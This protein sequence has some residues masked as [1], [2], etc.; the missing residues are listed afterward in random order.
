M[1]ANLH[2][3]SIDIDNRKKGI[4]TKCD[5]MFVNSYNYSPIVRL[6]FTL[7]TIWITEYS[8]NYMKSTKSKIS[9]LTFKFRSNIIALSLRGSF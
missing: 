9:V 4:I 6:L 3:F 7:H 1:D 5:C 2:E 8:D